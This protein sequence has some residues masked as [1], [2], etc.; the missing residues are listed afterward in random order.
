MYCAIG[1]QAKANDHDMCT[2]LKSY[3]SGV[4]LKRG[5]EGGGGSSISPLHGGT[6]CHLSL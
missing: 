4:L 2:V 6:E 3:A 1:M 5:R